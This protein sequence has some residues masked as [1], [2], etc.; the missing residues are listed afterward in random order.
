MK[1]GESWNPEEDRQLNALHSL[2]SETHADEKVL[3]FTQFADTG[4]YLIKELTRR[5]LAAVEQVDGD[6]ED[7][8]DFAKR[9]S[10]V[11]NDK[12][13][14]VGT[15]NEIRVLISTDVL[16]EGQNLQDAHI[17]LNYDLPWAIIRLIQRAGRVDRIGQQ[18]E[19][20]VCYS[21]LPE[22]GIEQI[23]RLRGRLSNRIR[24]NAEVVGSD[25]TFFEGDPVNIRDLYNENSGILDEHGDDSEVDLAS[26]AYQIWKNAVDEDPSVAKL[27]S[28]LPDVVYATK[29][30]NQ[31]PDEEGA[32]VYTRTSE[33]NDV[34]SW[35][36]TDGRVIS[37][38]QYAVLRAAECEKDVTP[39]HKI[40][41]HHELVAKGVE[42]AREEEKSAGTSL[43][44][45][46]SVKYRSYM[47]LDRFCKEN[48]GTLFVTE[49][50]K[51]AVDDI[52]NHTLTE[53]ARETINRQMKAGV[54]D[55]QL[56]ELVVSL[57]ED[58]KLVRVAEDDGTPKDPQIICS[59]GLKN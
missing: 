27:V 41:N 19:Q 36:G 57:R 44:K 42:M 40:E 21:F 15:Q 2:L 29:A 53:F 12:F 1:I 5:G 33:E 43:G 34:L 52:L 56:G 39:L 6:A 23:I 14:L 7:P 55:E 13:R 32:I 51:K 11:S 49:A 30:N 48:D 45:K 47:R 54:S 28:D 8:T 59:L 4:R 22:D 46:T 10:P 3:V 18:A 50:L 17:I 31:K 16:S 38:S 25:E 20:I 26:Y 24:E 35:I 9:F 58:E 37:Q